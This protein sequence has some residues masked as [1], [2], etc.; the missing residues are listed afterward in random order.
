MLSTQ[1]R[2]EKTAA[3]ETLHVGADQLESFIAQ[4]ANDI[5]NLTKAIAEL[6]SAMAEATELCQAEKARNEQPI[7]DAKVAQDAVSIAITVLEDFYAKAGGATVFV[8]QD[9]VVPEVFDDLDAELPTN[10]LTRKEQTAAVEALLAEVHQLESSIAQLGS[11]QFLQGGRA[12]ATAFGK[13]VAA[14][15]LQELNPV[16]PFNKEV[17]ARELQEA[18]ADR[19]VLDRLAAETS[20][21]Q[22][23][24]RNC[25]QPPV[26]RPP[27]RRS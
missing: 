26:H 16:N 15:E 6:D 5:A 22:I 11:S 27:I 13:E 7:A 10:V 1:A 9:P 2:K 3:V 21:M 24:R 20:A 17:A 23:P 14:R 4:L 12:L 25:P 8:Q 19:A 18:T